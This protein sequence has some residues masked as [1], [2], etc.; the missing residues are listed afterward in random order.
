MYRLHGLNRDAWRRYA[1]RKLMLSDVIFPGY[2]YNMPDILAS[3]GIHQLR[4]V[5]DGLA[6]RERYARIYD[7]AFLGISG[8]TLQERPRDSS[9]RHGLHLYVLVLDPDQFLA[10]R[11]HIID[12]L[13]AENIGAALHYRA[14]HMHPY[15]RDAYGYQPQDF[16]VAASVGERILSLPLTPYMS[17]QDV[18]DVI[19]AVRKVLAAYRR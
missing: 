9:S 17:E 12:A 11:N 13:L 7:Q 5:E 14:L 3:L 10:D 2:K 1:S 18:A 6:V 19:A 4:R 15:Y 16:P 8:V